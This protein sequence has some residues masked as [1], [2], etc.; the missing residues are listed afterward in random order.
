MY[1]GGWWGYVCMYVDVGACE[2]VCLYM[3]RPEVKH[4]VSSLSAFQ[5]TFWAM[6][7]HRTWSSL[8][9]LDE[10]ATKHQASPCL[11]VPPQYWV[12]DKCHNAWLFIGIWEEGESKHRSSH[13]TAKTLLV[14]S[15]DPTTPATRFFKAFQFF[16]SLREEGDSVMLCSLHSWLLIKP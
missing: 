1:G 11:P 2:H 14:I 10:L 3:R 15:Q 7:S 16:L 12:A 6:D 5:L 13:C 8:V 4:W 9:W